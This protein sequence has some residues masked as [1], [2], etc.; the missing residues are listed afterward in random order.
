MRDRDV[1][2][3]ALGWGWWPGAMATVRAELTQQMMNTRSRDNPLP[4][5]GGKQSGRLTRQEKEK[6]KAQLPN[7][8]RD[9]ARVHPPKHYIAYRLQFCVCFYQLQSDRVVGWWVWIPTPIPNSAA[10]GGFYGT[11]AR[12][13]HGWVGN[14]PPP[15]WDFDWLEEAGETRD[16]LLPPPPPPPGRPGSSNRPPPPPPPGRPNGRNGP[17]PPPPPPGRP[18]SSN[19][20]PPPP[21]PPPPR[22]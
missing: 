9:G 3:A 18:G 2:S 15:G 20:P 14:Q 5:G 13:G 16:H 19:R 12:L 17:P 7:D 8:I 1:F 22:A 6:L 21:P 11:M 10:D 4:Q